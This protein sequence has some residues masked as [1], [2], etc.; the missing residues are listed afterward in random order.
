MPN[1]T[2]VLAL[3]N[4]FAAKRW[5]EPA[6]WAEIIADFGIDAVEASADNECDPLYHGED[7]L[8]GWV[9][10]ARQACTEHPIRI[11]NLF[12]G[13]GSYATLGLSHPDAEVRARIRDGWI[14]PMIQVASQLD[15]GLGFFC[16]AFS[17]SVLQSPSEYRRA[18]DLLVDDLA[19]IA[20][21]AVSNHC[22]SV[23]VEQMYTPHQVPWTIDGTRQLL[24]DV[25][26]RGGAPLY[27]TLDLGHASAQQRYLRP[28]RKTLVDMI[29]N[30]DDGLHESQLPWLGPAECNVLYRK[31]L[32][33]NIEPVTAARAIEEVMDRHQYMFADAEDGDPYRWLEELSCYSPIIHLQQTDGNSSS[34]QAFTA[35]ANSQGIVHPERVIEAIRHCYSSINSNNSMPQPCETLYLTLEIFSSTA[36][37]PQDIK[38]RFAESVAYWRKWIPPAGLVL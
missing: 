23:A 8:K 31:M 13:H 5:T 34:H 3:D 14:K 11:A 36:D 2:L 18:Y 17:Q 25:L 12:S 15:A 19:D 37:R 6:E 30:G 29:E 24:C 26:S 28:T 10:K 22:H 27:V 33:E 20:R 1:P 38:A 35:K 4:C 32:S 9:A 16:H 7:Y 21:Y